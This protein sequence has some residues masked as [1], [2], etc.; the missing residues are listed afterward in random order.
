MPSPSPLP[1]A[2]VVARLSTDGATARHIGD[3][4]DRELRCRKRSRLPPSSSPMDAGR[5]PAF[6]RSTR[7]GGRAGA[8]RVRRRRGGG[9]C[10]ARSRRSRP[11]TGCARASRASRRS[12]P[13]VSSCTGRT[14]APACGRTASASRS[15][16]RSPSAPATT[17]PRAAACS[18]STRSRSDDGA[19]EAP[20]LPAPPP[21]RKKSRRARHRHR[22]R[23]ARHRRG[24]GAASTGAGERHRRPR[25]HHR[26]REC[27]H[28]PRRRLV[29]V[30][31]AGGLGAARF[32]AR[33]PY[34]L[35]FAN[36]LLEPLTR[37]ATPMARL[38]A[39]ERTGRAL[40]PARRRRRA[41]RLPAIVPAGSC[42][43]AASALEGWATLV[44]VRAARPASVGSTRGHLYA[45]RLELSAA[46]TFF[47]N[48]C[49]LPCGWSIAGPHGGSIDC[50]HVRSPLPV[51]RGSH[52][53]R[54]KR[55]A[56]R[57]AAHR[58]RAARLDRLHRAALR[59]PPERIRAGVARSG[60]PGSPALPAR[61][62]SRSFC[63]ERAVLFVDGR[64]TLQVARAG[65]YL[66]V[67]HRAPRGDAA[68]SLDRGQSH[69][70][71]PPRLRPLAAHGRGRR[72]AGQG[73]R[74]GRRRRWSR[75]SPT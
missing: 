71:R 27:T 5:S 39:P 10:A 3:A 73:L 59:S 67:R 63:M 29:E 7:R 44:L 61:P 49:F 41:P 11:R 20:D 66:A 28:Q 31:H 55:A 21:A 56:R 53:A 19:S 8:G 50:R 24:E 74:R 51:V 30:I 72:A 13:V 17:A 9:P 32:R 69:Q 12:R 33:A 40:R 38:V 68:G 34:A 1:A 35:V 36:I 26:A 6:P 60:S 16:R 4:L 15:R 42:S 25:G 70:R 58:T 52:R 18:R 45:Q 57:G 14:I 65:R 23:R 47:R 46:P 48:R 54:S 75:S 22:H 37:L 64:Y 62:A 2:T 43:C